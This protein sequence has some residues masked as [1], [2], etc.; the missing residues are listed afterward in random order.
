MTLP[1][2]TLSN[3]T[4]CVALSTNGTTWTDFSTYLGIIEPSAMTRTTGETAL[5]GNDAKLLSQGK[6]EAF[7]ITIRGVYADSTATTN[8]F[9]YVW[10]QW[11]TSCGGALAVRWAPAGC[12]TTNQVFSTATATGHNSKLVSLT[13]PAGDAD[14]GDALMWEAVIRTGDLWKAAYVA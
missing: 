14:S 11:T 6:K 3:C 12:A 8:P 4:V 13:P 10:G 7:D 1:A 2:G 5:F 9:A